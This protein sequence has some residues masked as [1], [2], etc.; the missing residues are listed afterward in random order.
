MIIRVHSRPRG[1]LSQERGTNAIAHTLLRKLSPCGQIF[2]AL[3]LNFAARL[4]DNKS[5]SCMKSTGESTLAT[6]QPA[7]VFASPQLPVSV[8][9]Q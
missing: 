5:A 6:P 1:R 3:A 7:A 2:N 4:I 8:P 9:F